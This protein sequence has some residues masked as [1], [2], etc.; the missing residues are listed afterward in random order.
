[1]ANC[2][3]N[4]LKTPEVSIYY[5]KIRV[6]EF[7]NNKINT[8]ESNKTKKKQPEVSIFNPCNYCINFK[9][10]TNYRKNSKNQNNL[11]E[12]SL[13]ANSLKI[14]KIHSRPIL[15]KLSISWMQKKLFF[16]NILMHV[17]RFSFHYKQHKIIFLS[18]LEIN[19]KWN[20]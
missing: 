9:K 2:I 11:V 17:K 18:F 6:P 14:I 16:Q 13:F 10:S 19:M 8:L 15:N 4:P 7:R 12:V 3:Q 20:K 1:M 5:F